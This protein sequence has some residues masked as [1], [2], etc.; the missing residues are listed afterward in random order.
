MTYEVAES[1][2]AAAADQD[3]D[4]ALA[5]WGMAITYFHPLWPDVPSDDALERGWALLQE[6]RD[7]AP[8]TG[9]EEAYIATL[10]TY[11]RD[12][13]GSDERTRLE[14][15]A[16]SWE[17]V[18]RAFPEDPEAALLYA[19]ALTA[20]ASGTDLTFAS[21]EKLEGSRSR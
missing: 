15:Y 21:H 5:Y 14:S 12:G 1:A 18:H 19:L 16:A 4:C 13:V 3:P 7:L 10:E 17:K 20:A 11:Y 9:R 6:A 8:G 2:F